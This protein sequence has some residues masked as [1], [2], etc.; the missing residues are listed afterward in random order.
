MNYNLNIIF[1]DSKKYISCKYTALFNGLCTK[2]KK[3]NEILS[4]SAKKYPFTKN[5]PCEY[6]RALRKYMNG[7]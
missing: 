7:A 3:N 1:P 2:P 6:V 4:K 5:F